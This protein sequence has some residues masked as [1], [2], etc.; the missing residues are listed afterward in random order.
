MAGPP[1]YRQGHHRAGGRNGSSAQ[2]LEKA[3][4][5]KPRPTKPVGRPAELCGRLVLVGP[6]TVAGPP[7]YCQGHHRAGGRNGSSAR[8]LRKT[9]TPKVS[10]PNPSADQ[11]SCADDWSSSARLPSLVR[12]ATAKGTTEPVG[13]TAR[14]PGYYEKPLPPRFPHQTRRPTSG[15]AGM[16]EVT[17]DH[18]NPLSYG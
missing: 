18:R 1:S 11:R 14:R 4:F 12:R 3:L 9:T 2:L 16:T 8:L 5:P 7:S 15:A 6:A 17:N 13:V 10:P